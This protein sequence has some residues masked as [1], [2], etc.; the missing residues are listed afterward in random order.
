MKKSIPLITSLILILLFSRCNNKGT[1]PNNSKNSPSTSQSQNISKTSENDKD[2]DQTSNDSQTKNNESSQISK[3][4]KDIPLKFGDKGEKVKE[5]QSKLNKFKYNLIVDGEFGASTDFGIRNF[6]TKVKIP[7]DG[8]AGPETLKLLDSTPIRDP[9]IYKQPLETS[10]PSKNSDTINSIENFINSKDCPSNTN[11]YIYTNLSNHTV[12]ILTGSNYNWK[13]LQFFTCSVGAASTPTIRGHFTV[14]TRGG[15]FVTDNGLI[16]KYFTQISGNYLFH[17]VLYDKKG[18]LVDGR[19]GY[20][21]SHGCI[22]LSV[23]NAKYIYD[24]IPSST[25]IWIQWE[26]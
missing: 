22:R 21:I 8:I 7:S 17:S 25:A 11:Y 6:Q 3:E 12:S 15:S 19:L 10:T 26:N 13:L 18:N 1:T 20:N 9:Y 2:T 5:L 16:C 14:E 4:T 23:E 24:N